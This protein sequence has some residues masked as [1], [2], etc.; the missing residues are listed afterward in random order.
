MSLKQ[1]NMATSIDLTWLNCGPTSYFRNQC[2][3]VNQKQHNKC[4]FYYIFFLP[5]EDKTKKLISLMR[6]TMI[7]FSNLAYERKSLPTQKVLEIES[8][9]MFKLIDTITHKCY[10]P[11]Y[12]ITFRHPSLHKCQYNHSVRAFHLVLPKLRSFYSIRIEEAMDV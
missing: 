7:F 11:L 9:V 8:E 5:L 12:V 2:T 3:F 1:K 6:P 10:Q 4:I